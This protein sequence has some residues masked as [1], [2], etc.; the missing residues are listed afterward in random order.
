MIYESGKRHNSMRFENLLIS[1]GVVLNVFYVHYL[2]ILCNSLA[3][4]SFGI[5]YVSF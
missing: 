1:C 4:L 5:T 3:Y 2:F